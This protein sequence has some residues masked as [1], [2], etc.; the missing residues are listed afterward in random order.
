MA[1]LT[2]SSADPTAQPAAGD[3][4]DHLAGVRE[5]TDALGWL[6]WPSG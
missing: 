6:G 5:A 4:A 2:T 3:V 1:A